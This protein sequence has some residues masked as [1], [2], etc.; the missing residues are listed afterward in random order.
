M[1]CTYFKFKHIISLV[2]EYEKIPNPDFLIPTL[3][4]E[5]IKS[6]FMGQPT[7][8]HFATLHMYGAMCCISFGCYTS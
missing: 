3:V 5:Q 1:L 8:L 7:Y 2:H 4:P 6:S